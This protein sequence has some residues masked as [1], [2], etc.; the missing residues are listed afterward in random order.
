MPHRRPR[1]CSLSAAVA[2]LVISPRSHC[3][4][5][6]CS[7]SAICEPHEVDAA[8][9]FLDPELYQGRAVA[10]PADAMAAAR[11]IR[12][13]VCRAYQIARAGIEK[14]A[15]LP[16]ELHRDVR[17]AI[18]VAVHLAVLTDHES[19]RRLAEIFHLEAHPAA[20]FR[21]RAGQA[22]QPFLVSH[23]FSEATVE[24]QS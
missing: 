17:A 3:S 19:R 1:R 7:F 20:R 24:T 8:G 13:T 4:F 23:S 10:R 2:S 6:A 9:A 18:Q 14:Y 11:V 15:F 22:D 12:S 16:V 5:S 21:Q